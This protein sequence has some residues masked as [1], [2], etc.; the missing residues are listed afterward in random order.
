MPSIECMY[1]LYKSHVHKNV[2]KRES[3][4]IKSLKAYH[5]LRD[6]TNASVNIDAKLYGTFLYGN[7]IGGSSFCDLFHSL[8]VGVNC[9]IDHNG[10][11]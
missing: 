3:K 10:C 11:Q 8:K 9:W 5:F 6:K 2:S 7:L 1:I 4:Y